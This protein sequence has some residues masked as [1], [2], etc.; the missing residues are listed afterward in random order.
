MTRSKLTSLVLGLGIGVSRRNR[1]A[2]SCSS[3]NLN[4]NAHRASIASTQTWS[5][6]CNTACAI[7]MPDHQGSVIGHRN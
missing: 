4:S 2:V 5:T 6:V 7:D 3:G 1:G